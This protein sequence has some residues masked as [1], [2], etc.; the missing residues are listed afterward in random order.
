MKPII[1]SSTQKHIGNCFYIQIPVAGK[2]D[3]EI[4]QALWE[5]YQVEKAVRLMLDGSISINDLLESVEHIFSDM[6]KY[7]DEVEE[8]LEEVINCGIIRCK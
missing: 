5:S 4:Q 8:N 7:A 2:C 6:D 3:E 1:D